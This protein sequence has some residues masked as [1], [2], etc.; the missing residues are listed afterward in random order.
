MESVIENKDY[1]N[2][3]FIHHSYKCRGLYKKQIERFLNYFPWQ[4]ILVLSSEEFFSE[5]HDT[6]R[7]VFNFVGV[8]TGFK[9]KDLKPRNVAKNKS[10]VDPDIYGYLNNYFFPHN[11][12]LYEIVGKSYGW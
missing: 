10:E 1:K 8:D 12:A 7:R 3:I 9:V 11:Q 6:L 2:D 4:Q 5:P